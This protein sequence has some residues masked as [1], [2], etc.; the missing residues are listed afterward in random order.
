MDVGDGEKA[1]T[2]RDKVSMNNL[3]S[4]NVNSSI[5]INKDKKNKEEKI[6]RKKRICKG[7]RKNNS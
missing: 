1:S 7:K 6:K 4:C 3:S 5:H 2:H